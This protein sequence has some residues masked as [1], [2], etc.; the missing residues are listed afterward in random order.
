MNGSTLR[1]ESRTANIR[2]RVPEE[3]KKR[4]QN[5]AAIRGLTLTDFLIVAANRETDEVFER[6]EKIELSAR[7]Q[8]ALAEMILN[9]PE[10]SEVFKTAL[11]ERLAQMKDS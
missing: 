3:I 4:W 2:A 11:K 5:A 8:M 7:D 10:L 9:P 6:E 1:N